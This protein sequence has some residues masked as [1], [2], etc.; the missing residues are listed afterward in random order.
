MTWTD[1]NTIETSWKGTDSISTDWGN[2]VSPETAWG[3]ETGLSASLTY[4]N[5]Y[6]YSASFMR[7]DGKVI[8]EE[9]TWTDQAQTETAWK[10]A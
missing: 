5:P 6:I 3:E 10:D 9:L 4:N 7:Y 8:L 1:Q 2:G